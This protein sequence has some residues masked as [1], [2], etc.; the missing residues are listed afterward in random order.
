MVMRVVMRIVMAR[1]GFK[2][3]AMAAAVLLIASLGQAGELENGDLFIPA[4]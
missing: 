4:E 1:K 3:A 2:K